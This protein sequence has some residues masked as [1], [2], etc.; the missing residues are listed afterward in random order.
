MSFNQIVKTMQ[1]IMKSH[2]NEEEFQQYRPIS[3]ELTYYAAKA[4]KEGKRD[5]IPYTAQVKIMLDFGVSFDV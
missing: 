5:Q 4:M 3:D 1:E 2:L